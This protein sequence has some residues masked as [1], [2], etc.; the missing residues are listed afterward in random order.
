MK[1]SDNLPDPSTILNNCNIRRFEWGALL[2]EVQVFQLQHN[3]ASKAP[4][5]FKLLQKFL[6]SKIHIV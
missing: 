5:N 1:R 2:S 6:I 3:L 4:E